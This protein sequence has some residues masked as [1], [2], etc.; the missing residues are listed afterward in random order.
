MF[1]KILNI[2]LFL[3]FF[4]NFGYAKLEI[5]VKPSPDFGP[6][7]NDDVE[8][9]CQ[10]VVDLFEKH[11]RPE[12][13][14]HEAVN[15]YRTAVGYNFFTLD[16]ADP[17]VKYKIGIQ[18]I[19]ADGIGYR[20][21]DFYYLL[22]PFTHEFCHLL[23]YPTTDDQLYLNGTPNLWL[24]EGIATMSSIWS[25]REMAKTWGND[26]KFGTEL[27]QAD[28][29]GYNFSQSFHH[30]ATN[31]LENAPHFQFEGTPAEWLEKHED[32]LRKVSLN[33]HAGLH[34]VVPPEQLAFRFLP[35]FE[36]NP[37]AWNIITKMPYTNG[38]IEEYM[39][40][41]YDAVDAQDRQ[42]VEAIAEIMDITVTSFVVALPEVI[43][44]TEIDA[45]VNDDG[46][47]DLYDVLIVRSGM[48]KSVSYDTDINN[49]GVTDEVDLLIVKAKAME[50]IAAAAP[51]KR[52]VKLTTWG[53][54]KK[55]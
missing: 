50:A 9:L 4:V 21:T 49:D 38:R 46:Y 54:M 52:K 44:L 30:F 18:P 27:W 8:Y 51:R 25:L 23:Q 2:S 39:Q 43:A 47:V 17:K 19:E 40:E 35:V 1:R 22:Q 10:K 6:M 26:P 20:I 34:F 45:D 41:W 31:T 55:R 14:I 11:L 29:N 32:T 3:L 12:N 16:V 42:Y 53:S 36:D 33:S 48:Q 13:E 24:M 28:G 5:I 7:S 37:E 15:V